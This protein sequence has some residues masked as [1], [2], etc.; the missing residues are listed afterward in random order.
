MT[1][2]DVRRQR[3][4]RMAVSAIAACCFGGI[5][6]GAAFAADKGKGAA[7]KG[8]KVAAAPMASSA[9]VDKLKFG[10]KWGLGPEGV[11]KKA[12]ERIEESYGERIKKAANDPTRQD[13]VRKEMRA[14]IDQTRKTAYVKFEGQKMGYDVSIID[15]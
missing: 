13:R 11:L 12:V 5:F 10:F 1:R 14:E 3:M 6:A 15:Q 9:E 4:T 8:G 7:A 2:I